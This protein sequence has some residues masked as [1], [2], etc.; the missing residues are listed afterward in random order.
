[1][2]K[3]DITIFDGGFEAEFVVGKKIGVETW[4]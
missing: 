3:A 1:L 2:L 4:K